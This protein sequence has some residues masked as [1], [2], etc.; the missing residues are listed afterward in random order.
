MWLYKCG[1]NFG[2]VLRM[3]SQ[4]LETS[5]RSES[6]LP[7]GG[8]DAGLVGAAEKVHLFSSSYIS[9]PGTRAALCL[10]N[11]PAMRQVVFTSAL[12]YISQA[13]DR[14]T[15]DYATADKASFPECR[16]RGDEFLISSDACLPLPCRGALGVRFYHV[17]AA[18]MRHH[19]PA[20]V[21]P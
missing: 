19:S 9:A 8:T 6:V 3:H 20:S 2:H 18:A 10:D 15:Q 21:L 16:E 4:T 17:A 1:I 14:S 11:T 5:C 13:S 12:L 7:N